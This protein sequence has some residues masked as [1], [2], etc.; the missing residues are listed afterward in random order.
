MDQLALR[1]IGLISQENSP[2]GLTILGLSALIEYVFPPFPGDTVTLFGA[3]LITARGW[4]FP[5]VFGTVLFGSAVGAMADF[6]LGRVLSRRRVGGPRIEKLVERFRRH[7]EAY[8]VINRFLPGV[9]ALFFVAAGMAGMRPSRVLLW[10]TVSAALWN[11]LLIAA[12]S[13]VGANFDALLGI[14]TTYA[15]LV[16]AALGVVALVWIGRAIVRRMRK[17]PT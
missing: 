10:A 7:G 8:L 2:I 9:R 14:F 17:P 12:G 11:L 6:W 15:R 3:F 4:S 1:L 16:W 13:A 5:A